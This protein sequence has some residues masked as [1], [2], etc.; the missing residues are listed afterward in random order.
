[1]RMQANKPEGKKT[2]ALWSFCQVTCLQAAHCSYPRV[3]SQYALAADPIS[4]CKNKHHS[5]WR[6]GL[7][8]LTVAQLQE[9][10]F[11]Y[12]AMDPPQLE[13]RPS[14][15]LQWHLWFEAAL[16]SCHQC[17][18]S[19]GESS[20]WQNHRWRSRSA[21]KSCT[22]PKELLAARGVK[23]L[24]SQNPKCLHKFLGISIVHHP[25]ECG[26]HEN[27]PR[28]CD[29]ESAARHL[30]SCRSRFSAWWTQMETSSMTLNSPASTL[31][32]T[33]GFVFL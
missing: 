27:L 15:M 13:Y 14:H 20:G 5:Y 29:S 10:Q 23:T 24:G 18:K 32:L 2:Q 12:L 11:M 33:A 21:P 6:V 30:N 3:S 4:P 16:R 31:S 22:N 25:V 28:G 17:Y 1:M 9:P 26:V 8:I 19:N 7:K